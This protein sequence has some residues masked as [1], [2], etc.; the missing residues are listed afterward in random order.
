MNQTVQDTKETAKD[1]AMEAGTQ[2]QDR[3]KGELDS[4][5]TGVGETLQTKADNLHEVGDQM[6]ERGDDT[7]AQVADRVAGWTEDLS[8]YLRDANA[9]RM[10]GDVEAFARRQ[11]WTMAAGGALLGFAA[12]RIVRAGSDRRRQTESPSM[13]RDEIDLTTPSPYA[14]PVVPVAPF[15]SEPS[16]DYDPPSTPA[17]SG[18]PVP[19]TNP[20]P[21]GD[22]VPDTSPRPGSA[23][24]TSHVNH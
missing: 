22:P 14:A 17:P 6:R 12:S 24:G 21:L 15:A 18:D 23:Y 7:F 13:G 9:D 16:P 5:T 3:A 10:I 2:A 20:A 11:P 4:R 1:K 8:R 19:D